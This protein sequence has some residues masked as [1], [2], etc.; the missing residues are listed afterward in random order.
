M[1]EFSCRVEGPVHVEDRIKA[2]WKQRRN[3]GRPSED[4]TLGR[5]HAA[6]QR[7]ESSRARYD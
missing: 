7:D 4:G 1:P 5:D 2:E 3:L 6:A